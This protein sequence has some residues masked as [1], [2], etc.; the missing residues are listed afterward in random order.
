MKSIA[1]SCKETLD[2]APGEIARRILDVTELPNFKGFGPMPGIK[3]AEFELRTPEIVGSRIQ[4][5]NTNGSK[6]VEEIVEWQPDCRLRLHMKD[7]SAPLSRLATKIEETWEFERTGISTE[8][9]RSFQIH[10]KFLAAWP[11]L[12]MISFFL[13]KAIARHLAW[14]RN[15]SD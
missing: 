14:M 2:I 15:L 7:F 10:A 9:T 3:S 6:H 4:V 5:V 8:V 12:W 11:L 1:F 13:R